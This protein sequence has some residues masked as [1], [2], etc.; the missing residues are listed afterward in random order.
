MMIESSSNILDLYIS[1]FLRNIV[2]AERDML[3]ILLTSPP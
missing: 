2:I 1:Q 3:S